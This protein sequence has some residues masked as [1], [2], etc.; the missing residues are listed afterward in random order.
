MD[1]KSSYKYIDKWYHVPILNLGTI[2]TNS[3]Y[4]TIEFMIKWHFQKLKGLG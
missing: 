2:S 1:T 4:L 3:G